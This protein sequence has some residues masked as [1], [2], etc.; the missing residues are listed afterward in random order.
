MT[1]AGSM[2]RTT[3]NFSR[4][5]DFEILTQINSERLIGNFL[6][7]CQLIKN[8]NFSM[9]NAKKKLL[10]VFHSHKSVIQPATFTLYTISIDDHN[11][12]TCVCKTITALNYNRFCLYLTREKKR[13]ILSVLWTKLS[14]FLWIN[15]FYSNL[16]VLWLYIYPKKNGKNR[17]KIS[18]CQ[19]FAHAQNENDLI[20]QRTYNY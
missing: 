4:C 6:L 8:Q 5:T 7:C 13:Q 19:T 10:C 11:T 12:H 18:F 9:I 14:F 20:F 3:Y 17:E 16:L 15:R 1:I 2:K